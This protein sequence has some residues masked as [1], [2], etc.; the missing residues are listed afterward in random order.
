MIQRNRPKCSRKKLSSKTSPNSIENTS[1]KVFFKCLQLCLKRNSIT[2]VLLRLLPEIFL[3]S[4]RTVSF[5]KSIN[6][7]QL[8]ESK[9]NWY[10]PRKKL[11]RRS[12][13][14]F[15]NC[16]LTMSYK[17]ASCLKKTLSFILKILALNS[18]TLSYNCN[19][20]RFCT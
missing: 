6:Y 19:I 3:G 10:T 7:S 13:N 4:F 1:V 16:L 11:F 20:V 18:Y 15:T 2:E 17:R 5:K 14:V 12:C 9:S 8:D